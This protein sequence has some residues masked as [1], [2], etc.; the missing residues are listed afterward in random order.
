MSLSKL[1]LPGLR[2]GI[3]VANNEIIKAIGRVNGSMVLSPNSIGPSLVTRLIT[4]PLFL[5]ALLPILKIPISSTGRFGDLVW[6][7]ATIRLF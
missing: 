2:S 3:V 4:T 7:L 1:G 5:H 6:I